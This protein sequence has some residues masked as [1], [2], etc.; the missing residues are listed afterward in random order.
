MLRAICDLSAIGQESYEDAQM[1][2]LLLIAAASLFAFVEMGEASASITCPRT[3]GYVQGPFAGTQS[4]ARR[5][6]STYRSNIGRSP[7]RSDEFIVR[8]DDAGDH[9]EVCESRALPGGRGGTVNICMG[10]GMSIDKCTG[11]V[12][13]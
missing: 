2:M 11:A 1:K 7:K 6:F 12:R 10:L 5:L 4:A 13:G 8:V 3:E 9:W